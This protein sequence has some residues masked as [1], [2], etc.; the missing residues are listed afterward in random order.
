MSY[1]S[2]ITTKWSGSRPPWQFHLACMWI[3]LQQLEKHIKR[4]N[5]INWRYIKLFFK[6]TWWVIVQKVNL[7]GKEVS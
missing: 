4:G 5:G 2:L 6:Q 3:C 7:K 1:Y